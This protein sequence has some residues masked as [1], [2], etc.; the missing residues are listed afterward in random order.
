M[1]NKEFG[2][3]LEERTKSFAIRIIK[4]STDLPGS[5]EGKII[6]NQLTKSGTSIGANYREANRGRSK[7]DFKNKIKI[8]ESETN[9]TCYWLE[10]VR[11]MKWTGLQPVESSLNE[12]NELLAIF[13]PI[14]KNL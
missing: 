13:T 11:D 2:K 4:L 1:E 12:S 5:V 10:I 6:R 8:C 7:A 14:G 9:E 3:R